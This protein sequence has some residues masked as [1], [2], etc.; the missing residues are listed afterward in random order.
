MKVCYI[1]VDGKTIYPEYFKEKD[2]Q[3]AIDNGIYFTT[4]YSKTAEK[5]YCA[6]TC[7]KCNAISG[8]FYIKEEEMEAFYADNLTQIMLDTIETYDEQYIENTDMW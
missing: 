1:D 2:K 6:N 8:N 5:S 7:S 4:Q 3:L